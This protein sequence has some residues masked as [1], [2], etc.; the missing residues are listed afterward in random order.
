MRFRNW[1]ISRKSRHI[2]QGPRYWL[3]HVPAKFVQRVVNN[4]PSNSTHFVWHTFKIKYL[5]ETWARF[6]SP[7]QSKLRLCL[8][9]HRA[10]YFSNMACD[11]LS[12]VWAYSEQETENGPRFQI[13]SRWCTCL[14]FIYSLFYLFL[15]LYSCLSRHIDREGRLDLSGTPCC[16]VGG[17][18]PQRVS[19][20]E[21]VSRV[22]KFS[23]FLDGF[24]GHQVDWY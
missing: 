24:V 7:A 15:F 6:L 13:A 18:L 5:I 12:I 14:F 4:I 17:F 20:A 9:N 19:N 8:A 10:G 21:S 3:L 1:V 23:W 11:W 16:I 22:M 2:D